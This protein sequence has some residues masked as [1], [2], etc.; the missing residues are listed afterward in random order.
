MDATAATANMRSTQVKEGSM[1]SMTLARL[2]LPTP[3]AQEARGN[4]SD[5]RGKAN[6]TD[7][8]AEIYAPDSATSQLNPQF[9]A[10]MMGFPVN[11]TE[12]PFRSGVTN[13]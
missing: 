3:K 6:L 2:L 12:L 8:I 1:Y 10:E 11:W 5:D 4:A 9:V 7:A 13:P